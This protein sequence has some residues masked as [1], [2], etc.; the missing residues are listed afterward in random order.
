MSLSVLGAS[1]NGPGESARNLH[2]PSRRR[3]NG[4][5]MVIQRHPSGRWAAS[6]TIIVA[7]KHGQLTSSSSVRGQG[8]EIERSQ[9]P[10]PV[11]RAELKSES[12]KCR[13]CSSR[14]W[15]RG[16]IPLM[17]LAASVVEVGFTT[18]LR[19]TVGVR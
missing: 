5:H 8:A 15:L 10:V 12:G 1:V 7:T 9:P 14:S 16:L 6:P 3:P 11:F 17:I 4:K 18:C 19:Y 2:R 13:G